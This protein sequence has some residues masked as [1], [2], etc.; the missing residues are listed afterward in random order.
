M[1]SSQEQMDIIKA[2]LERG[3]DGPI[4]ELIE[5][6]IIQKQNSQQSGNPQQPQAGTP[7][8][9]GKIPGDPPKSSTERNIIK[10]GQYRDGGVNENVV[11][12][13][14]QVYGPA[15]NSD[16]AIYGSPEYS[17]AYYEGRLLYRNQ[18]PTSD[19]FGVKRLPQIDIVWDKELNQP[20]TEEYPFYSQLNEEQKKYFRDDTVLGRGVRATAKYGEGNYAKTVTDFAKAFVTQPIKTAGEVL[21]TPA[22]LLAE[23]I[24]QSRGEEYNYADALPFQSLYGENK[25]RYVS[26][27]V[28]FDKPEGF[29]QNAANIGLDI[30]TDPANIIGAGLLSKSSLFSKTSKV[31]NLFDVKSF[32]T[33]PSTSL[34]SESGIFN[35]NNV[36]TKFDFDHSGAANAV[37]EKAAFQEGI[38]IGL[39]HYKKNVVHQNNIDKLD[40]MGPWGEQW[41]NNWNTGVKLQTYKPYMIPGIGKS[42]NT[43]GQSS[44]L[45]FHNVTSSPTKVGN[46]VVT[47]LKNPH[48]AKQQSEK[49][50]YSMS[51]DLPPNAAIPRN[52]QINFY[53]NLENYRAGK[54]KFDPLGINALKLRSTKQNISGLT[55]HEIHHSIGLPTTNPNVFNQ[56]D[57]VPT[58]NPNFNPKLDIG[59]N[60]PVNIYDVRQPGIRF[61]SGTVLD[62]NN[63]GAYFTT[64]F[65]QQTGKFDKEFISKSNL[66][67]DQH[68]TLF[69]MQQAPVNDPKYKHFLDYKSNVK[70]RTADMIGFRTKYNLGYKEGYN[71]L[72]DRTASELFKKLERHDKRYHST[73]KDVNSFKNLFEIAPYS[74]TPAAIG[75]SLLLNENS[76][77]ENISGYKKGGIKKQNGGDG[78]TLFNKLK[79]GYSDMMDKY[80]T[81]EKEGFTIPSHNNALVNRLIE[82]YTIKGGFDG[83]DFEV[84][85][86]QGNKDLLRTKILNSYEDF[87]K[88]SST[89]S[90]YLPHNVIKNISK[91]LFE[92]G[93][94]NKKENGGSD[95]T[96]ETTVYKPEVKPG[97]FVYAGTPEYNVAYPNVVRPVNDPDIMGEITLPEVKIVADK[98]TG[99]DILKEYPYYHQ[100]SE[101][102]K[103]YFR[104]EGVLG[105]GVRATAQYGAGNYA[106]SV[107]DMALGMFT[108]GPKAAAEILQTPQ[109][110]LTEGIAQLKGEKYS[111]SDALPT[112]GSKENKQRVLSDVIGFEDKPGWDLGGSLNTAMNIFGDPTV[113]TGVG[114]LGKLNRTSK[115]LNTS[116]SILK[117]PKL[118]KIGKHGISKEGFDEWMKYR[119]IPA[120]YN[121]NLV[122]APD[123]VYRAVRNPLDPTTGKLDAAYLN[124]P[125][126]PILGLT[127]ITSKELA[128]KTALELNPNVYK[129]KSYYNVGMSTSTN[130]AEIQNFFAYRLKDAEGYYGGEK[131]LN[132]AMKGKKKW[133]LSY[134]LTPDQ[135]I[136][137]PLEYKNF[138]T[139]PFAG[140][141]SP[142]QS[143]LGTR[144]KA[145]ILD[146]LGYT[147][148][149]KWGDSD[150]IQFLNPKKSLILKNVEEI[151]NLK[152]GGVKRK[153]GERRSKL[154]SKIKESRKG[155][156]F[157]ALT[158]DV[159]THKMAYGEVDGKYHVYP[160]LFQDEQG[161]WYSAGYDEAKRKGEIYVFDTEKEAAKWAGQDSPYK[162]KKYGPGYRMGGKKRKC[163][164]GCW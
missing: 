7:A 3:Y 56:Y 132:L 116:E 144:D 104:D 31:D 47:D 95:S 76:K 43:M 145:N 33:N 46:I 128:E 71:K 49:G 44:V 157:N 51:Q 12:Y 114:T 60:N 112:L 102:Q 22:S 107:K 130:K 72:D 30:T 101:E 58:K 152:K 150:E 160:T 38:D 61:G 156:Q 53:Q 26:D 92:K 129:H 123:N 111:Y 70:E 82:G 85:D 4:Y 146:K 134:E 163:K 6:A 143:L 120:K 10:P 48:I 74:L 83:K 2:A 28:G 90:P 89:I 140:G 63:E 113:L 25:Q 141:T 153:G 154:I 96:K 8:L 59:P 18:D 16:I 36:V 29:W 131:G 142:R 69:D 55:G 78:D 67:I 124:A 77:K 57:I 158:G 1:L 164:Y 21:Q 15:Q 137:N 103:K 106:E 155:V 5:Q 139:D 9:G 27:I 35:K 40:A 118:T 45:D 126:N 66:G 68:K 97:D 17:K 93:G 13:D 121:T 125:N 100:L 87:S 161:E 11:S 138:M 110:L 108:A 149:K 62:V 20:I 19:A 148:I 98:Y 54:L 65:N 151:S 81:Y 24:A 80:Q 84:Y 147:G 50:I 23:S 75:G 133:N 109:S 86:P 162:T 88:I 79:A 32:K 52:S 91:N 135:K 105:R 159:S 127:K 42:P 64:K 14:D 115:V 117:A 94:F 99:E 41:K 34:A 73:F 39:D 136:L 37:K 122:D 119:L